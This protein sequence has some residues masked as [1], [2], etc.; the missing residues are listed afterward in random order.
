MEWFKSHLELESKADELRIWELGRIPGLLQT[1]RYAGAL[2]EAC[3]VEDVE[4]AVASRLARQAALDRTPR[5]LVW[6]FLDQGVLEQPVGGPGVMREQLERLAEL[7]RR[8]NIT[9]RI[10]P[11]RVGAHV[12]RDG[13]FKIMTVAGIEHVYAEACEGG[14]LVADNTDVGL[15]RMRFAR[16]GDWALPIDASLRLLQDVLEDVT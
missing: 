8:P 7:A 5:P 16:I 1:E 13:S 3:G 11:R 4:S 12:G 15:F 10:M 9:V 14:R 6:V 2:F